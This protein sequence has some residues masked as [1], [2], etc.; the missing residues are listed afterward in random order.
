[1]K[2]KAMK[3]KQKE[4]TLYLT[5][6]T[7]E[8]LSKGKVDEYHREEGKE[9]EGYQRMPSNKRVKEYAKYVH[10]TPGLS[11]TSV[12]ISVR[13][14]IKFI[15]KTGVLEIPDKATLWIVDGQH[16]IIG[17]QWLNEEKNGVCL[18]FPLPVVVLPIYEYVNSEE[19]K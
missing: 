17:L 10:L 6:M 8:Q 11:P 13:E 12:T 19:E 5:A 15:E 14:P 7:A 4:T 16:R 9:P 18:D 2:L 1:M 3:I